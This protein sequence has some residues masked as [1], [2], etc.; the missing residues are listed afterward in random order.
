MLR[1]R[2]IEN[3]I[4]DQVFRR[5]Y[6]KKI[7]ENFACPMPMHIAHT[8]IH[9]NMYARHKHTLVIYF[10]HNTVHRAAVFQEKYEYGRLND[11]IYN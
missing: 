11:L 1:L 3:P 5:I 8:I 6:L 7:P 4:N 10:I 9:L 2:V